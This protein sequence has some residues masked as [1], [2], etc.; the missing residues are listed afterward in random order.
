MDK[1][2]ITHINDGFTFLGHR[3]I[4]KRGS[5]GDMIVVTGI[6]KEKARAFSFALSKELS[7]DLSNSMI[8]K[9]EKLNQKLKGWAQFYRYTDFTARVYCK[10][11]QVVF[12]KFAKWLSRKSK[13]RIKPLLIKWYKKPAPGL[14]KTWVLFGKTDNGNLC[15]I[16]LFRLVSSLKQPFRW[17]LPDSNPYLRVEE[18]KTI[19]SYY[20]DVAM[21]ISHN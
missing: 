18:R 11:D 15:G 3:I 9:V 5:T 21:A 12:W 19:T 13:C 1:T 7:G 16:S 14:S 20:A 8:D 17:R 10:I 2:K 6:P 4:R